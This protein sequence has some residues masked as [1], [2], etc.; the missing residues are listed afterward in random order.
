MEILK[1]QLGFFCS[2]VKYVCFF[3]GALLLLGMLIGK[4][5]IS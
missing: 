4:V 1:K 2:A 3:V 5:T